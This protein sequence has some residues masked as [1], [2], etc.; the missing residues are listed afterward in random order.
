MNTG[1]LA[2]R[3]GLL[4]PRHFSLPIHRTT[5]SVQMTVDAASKGNLEVKVKL[6][7]TVAASLDNLTAL[8]RVGGWS[9]DAVAR[10]AKDL[11]SVLQ[12]HVKSY[13]E[14]HGI[15]SLSSEKIHEYPESETARK[16]NLAWPGSDFA[17][18]PFIRTGQSPDLRSAETAGACAHP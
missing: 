6:G 2:L 4:Y 12:G 3:K 17:D 13:T 11:E 5:H 15:E 9:A 7:V 8:I 16:Q 18:D 10:A 1:G 14:Q